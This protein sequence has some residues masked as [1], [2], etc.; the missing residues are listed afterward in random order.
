M[1]KEP[2]KINAQDKPAELI[3]RSARIKIN[4]DESGVRLDQFLSKKFS[5]FSRS[6]LQKMIEDGSILLNK[7]MTQKKTRLV[8]G[9]EITIDWPDEE[10]DLLPNATIKFAIIY[11]DND[12]LVIDKPANLVVHPGAGTEDGTLV[13]ALLHHDFTS[14]NAMQGNE[15]RP[16]IVHRLDKNTTGVMVVAKNELAKTRLI[17]EFKLGNTAKEYLALVNGIS[18][19]NS[20]TIETLIGRSPRNRKKMGVV[21]ENGKQAI[22]S[23][24]VVAQKDKHSLLKI[25]IKT[26]RT[27]QIRVHL[28]HINLPVAGDTLYNKK[29]KNDIYFPRQMLH[30]LT[31]KFHHPTSGELKTFHAEQPNDMIE[32]AHDIGLNIGNYDS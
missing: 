22:T 13:N 18:D 5:A 6:A 23:Y 11:E 3:T 16:G 32:A 2:Q 31:L 27:H 9:D 17:E 20:G 30:A 29:K 26:G 24:Q 4:K 8:C 1:Y 15:L 19:Y 21:N 25:K 7:K 28:A 14:F 12:I 10:P